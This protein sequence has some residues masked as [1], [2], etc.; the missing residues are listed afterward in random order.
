MDVLIAGAGVIGCSAAAFLAEAGHSV[1]VI[2]RV[3]IASGASGRNSGVLQYPF[4]DVL[5]P[6]HWQT[7]EH[8]R[9][10]I[11]LQDEPDGT[12]LLGTRETAGHAPVL[13]AE[14]VEEARELDPLV[15]PGIPGVLLHMGYVVGPERVTLAWAERA[16]EAGVTFEQGE[17]TPAVTA[18][19]KA[20]VV[21]LATGAW[22]P[23]VSP[24]WGVTVPV[25]QTAKVIIEQAG[26]DDVVDG[27]GGVAFGLCGAV[28]GSTA[29]RT[30]PDPAQVAPALIEHAKQFV[31]GVEAAG[32]ARACPRPN[33]PDGRPLVGRLDDRTWM[34]AGHGAWGISIGVATAK[35][36]TDA[37]LD[38]KPI[39]EGLDPLRFSE[40]QASVTSP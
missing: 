12:L 10:V 39:P 35:L 2:D 19:S 21:I 28:L 37:I 8:H 30:E 22:A 15:H 7:V 16:R 36:L 38:G 18:A 23:G 31:S 26:I 17:W 40:V 14:V 1:T 3:G 6:L 4:D 5:G 27:G 13:R 25:T 11:D 24:L 20:D 32:P 34:C 33:S 29:S 9:T